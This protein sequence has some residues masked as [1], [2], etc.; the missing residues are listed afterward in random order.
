M[1]VEGKNK[2]EDTEEEFEINNNKS[3]DI[4]NYKDENKEDVKIEDNSVVTNKEGYSWDVEG[5]EASF[6]D[7]EII[8]VLIIVVINSK[9]DKKVI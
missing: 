6:E 4:G 8:V 7:V 9:F 3:D 5:G 2:G 1:K